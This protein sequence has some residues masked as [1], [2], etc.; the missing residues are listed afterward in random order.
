MKLIGR[1]KL[2]RGKRKEQDCVHA[3]SLQSCPALCNPMEC[4]LPGSSVHGILQARI[5]EWVAFPPPRDLPVQGV[6]PLVNES[7]A[8]Q[9][10]SLPTEPPGKPIQKYMLI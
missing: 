3:Q 6:E 1:I 10:D 7:L 2:Q 8:L 4:N 9:V 5:Q